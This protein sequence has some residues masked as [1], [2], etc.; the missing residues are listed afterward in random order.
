VRSKK[1][2][3]NFEYIFLEFCLKNLIFFIKSSLERTN[4]QKY[5]LERTIVQNYVN[6][7]KIKFMN[8]HKIKF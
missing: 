3:L 1:D 6:V 5:I 8:V 7:H 4:D 2:F